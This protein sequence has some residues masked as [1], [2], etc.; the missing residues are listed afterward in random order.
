VKAI[1]DASAYVFVAA[2]F[3]PIGD[4]EFVESHHEAEQD[5]GRGVIERRDI[6]RHATDSIGAT[7]AAAVPW[8]YTSAIEDL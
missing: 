2:D 4:C 7:P 8:R 3:A 6:R 5:S 1:S